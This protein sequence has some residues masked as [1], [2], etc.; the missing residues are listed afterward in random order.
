MQ[1]WIWRSISILI[2]VYLPEGGVNID[3]YPDLNLDRKAGCRYYYEKLQQAKEQ[4]DKGGED[5]TSGDENYDKL[6]DQMDSGD[7]MESDH[8]TSFAHLLCVK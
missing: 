7:G 2:K 5:G 1:Q 6:C 3:D 4:K 8:P